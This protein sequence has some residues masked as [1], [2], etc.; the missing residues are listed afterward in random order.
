MLQKIRLVN[1]FG[2]LHTYSHQMAHDP[3]RLPPTTPIVPEVL[4][5]LRLATICPFLNL[6]L[7]DDIECLILATQY[8]AQTSSYLFTTP[9]SPFYKLYT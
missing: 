3:V 2:A 4:A 1:N 9:S 6:K 5:V 8:V 7:Y